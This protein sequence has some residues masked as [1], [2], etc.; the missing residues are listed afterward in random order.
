M[1]SL[2]GFFAAIILGCVLSMTIALWQVVRQLKMIHAALVNTPRPPTIQPE[3]DADQRAL[4]S[5]PRSR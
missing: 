5:P 2:Q 1:N 3:P 4:W